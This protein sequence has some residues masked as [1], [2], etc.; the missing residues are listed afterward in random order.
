L[1]YFREKIFRF[2]YKKFDVNTIL[3]NIKNYLETNHPFIEFNFEILNKS[4]TEQNPE[5]RIA[6]VIDNLVS[7]FIN[8]KFDTTKLSLNISQDKLWDSYTFNSTPVKSKLPNDWAKRKV[9]A[10]QRD[11]NTCQRCGINLK[12]DKAKLHIIHPIKDG[13]KYYLDNLVI[14]CNDCDKISSKANT[15]YL[16]IKEKLYDLNIKPCD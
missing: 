13:G 7:Q 3:Q 15:N 2:Y 5:I 8:A 10:L 14:L 11:N 16:D 1:Y 12:A 9:V 4:K 6:M